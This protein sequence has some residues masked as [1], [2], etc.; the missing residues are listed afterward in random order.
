[1]G[2]YS[3]YQISKILVDSASYALNGGNSSGSTSPGGSNSQIQYN[4]SGSF[5]G[6]SILTFNGTQINA[7]NIIASGSFSGSFNGNISNAISA[8]YALTAS[9]VSNLNITSSIDT[10]SLVQYSVYNN[11]T[12]SYNINSESFDNRI[13]ILSNSTSSYITNSQTASMS[14]LSASY[15]I[16][17]SYSRN[18]TS[19]S[20]ALSASYVPNELSNGTLGQTLI[21]NVSPVWTSILIDSIGSSSVNFHDRN[22]SDNNSNI[23]LDWI[24]RYTN[25]IDG[26]LSIDWSER[27]L[28]NFDPKPVINWGTSI[29]LDSN[30]SS[31]IEWNSRSLLYSNNKSSIYYGINNRVEI[32]GSLLI[33]GSVTS[34]SGFTGSFSGSYTGSFTGSLLGTSSWAQNSITSSTSNFSLN[35][36]PPS[37]SALPYYGSSIKVEPIWGGFFNFG[38]SSL[39]L[40]NQR[41]LLSPVYIYDNLSITGVKWIQTT[42]GNYTGNNYNGVGLFSLSNGTLTNVASSSNSSTLW[43]TFSANSM[44][45]ASFGSSY[46]AS[47]GLYYIGTIWA[48]SS[49]TTAPAIGQG[50]TANTYTFDFTN[51]SKSVSFLAAQTSMPVSLAMSSTTAVSNTIYLVLY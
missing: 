11:F 16:S 14:V 13:K 34:N 28:Y 27:K 32:S 26:V 36:R 45:S 47:P 41:L 39:T 1:M 7:S 5:G 43:S 21:Y 44:G 29:L 20:Y 3:K 35:S 4:N 15:S 23:S 51:S 12:Q 42:Q 19:A 46:N 17:S 6:I 18:S 10:S 37:T 22:L 8:S 33:S 49:S 38:A 24:D 40:V 25:D 31:S 30:G 9:Y 48:N 50:S 2:G